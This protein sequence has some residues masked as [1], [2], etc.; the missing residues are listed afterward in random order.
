MK[1]LY[2]YSH[3]LASPAALGE[4]KD[5]LPVGGCF[6]GVVYIASL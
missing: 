2:L 5:D 6:S 4:N 3:L 1:L